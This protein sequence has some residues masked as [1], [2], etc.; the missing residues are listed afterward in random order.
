MSVLD[1]ATLII[2]GV[3]ETVTFKNENNGY[4]VFDLDSGG[5]LITVVGEIG[6][7]EEG[8]KLK[9]EGCYVNHV[10][11]GPQF[12]AEYCERM[13]PNTAVHIQKYLSSGAIKGIGPSLA[14]KIVSVF[15]DKTLEVRENTPENLLEIKGISPANCEK[16][17]K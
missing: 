4:V 8:E 16:I 3:V 2:E 6:E 13:L 15:G 1:N 11:F 9:L 14:R 10:K 12:Q 17:T 7:V 5:E